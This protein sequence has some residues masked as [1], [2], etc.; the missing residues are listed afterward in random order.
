MPLR[1]FKA[2]TF[3]MYGTLIDW[4]TGITRAL[5]PL[6]DRVGREMS[7]DE[8]LEEHA[9]HES[10]QQQA[11]PTKRYRDV[12]AVVYRRLAEQWRIT[13]DWDECVRYGESVQEWPAFPD[14][15]EALTYLKGHYQL[16]V[17]SNVDNESFQRSREKL[18]VAFDGV[19]SAEDIGSYKPCER[20][21]TYMIER[22]AS[23]GIDKSVILHTAESMYHDHLPANRAGLRSCHIHR[24]SQRD[25]YGA[26]M[27]PE[28]TAHCEFRFDS[29][30]EFVQAHRATL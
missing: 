9:R 20:N 26:T 2:L 19:Y 11:T 25:G 28:E 24:R 15:A 27:P 29:M 10:Y 18:G 21:F 14:S 12:L 1:D 5:R 17:L 30:A 13:V 7:R 6:T 16:F 23:L 22:M 4:E 3:D 8:V